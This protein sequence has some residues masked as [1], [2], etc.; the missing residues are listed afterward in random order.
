MVMKEGASRS[1]T[2]DQRVKKRVPI[3]AS[4][5]RGF[6]FD[7][8]TGG[9]GLSDSRLYFPAVELD[10]KTYPNVV[11]RPPQL[12]LEDIVLEF[13][14]VEKTLQGEAEVERRG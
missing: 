11:V 6:N 9:R 2:K 10:V 3:F 13:M 14:W 7:L 4:Y 8:P 1:M 5:R 12:V